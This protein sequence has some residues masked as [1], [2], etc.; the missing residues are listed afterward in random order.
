MNLKIKQAIRNIITRQLLMI[1][2][3]IGLALPL[4][5][6]YT[7]V[8][9]QQ[10]GNIYGLL[11]MSQTLLINGT[12]NAQSMCY[13]IIECEKEGVGNIFS[14]RSPYTELSVGSNALGYQALVNATPITTSPEYYSFT[15]LGKLPEGRYT[16]CLSLHQG[17]NLN[18]LAN[19]C[20]SLD[21]SSAGSLVLISPFDEEVLNSFYPN[22][23]WSFNFIPGDYKV[24]YA[25]KIAELK[26]NQTYVDAIS[27]NPVLVFQDNLESPLFNYPTTAFTLNE[28]GRYVWQIAVSINGKEK[29]LSE[30]WMFQYKKEKVEKAKKKPKDEVPDQYPHLQK[31][32]TSATYQFDKNIA[33]RYNNECRDTILSYAIFKVGSSSKEKLNYPL[34][35]ITSGIN[36][37]YFPVPKDMKKK[38]SKPDVFLLTVSNSRKENWKLKFFLTE[39]TH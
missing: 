24:S 28:E 30:I 17:S 33:F 23:F 4:Y 29:Y 20:V 10:T 22:F 16:L 6:Q 19:Q 26:D 32:L 1:W 21:I 25:I 8:M 14:L 2:T 39:K 5:S 13:A 36:Y 38:N 7:V 9:P 12:A 11:E 18:P 31:K 3:S 34:V 15:Q 35:K 27:F 37:I